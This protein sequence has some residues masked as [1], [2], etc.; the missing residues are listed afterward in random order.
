V[1]VALYHDNRQ[2]RHLKGLR[3]LKE[4]GL[5]PVLGVVSLDPHYR[6]TA[7]GLHVWPWDLFLRQLWQGVLG[8]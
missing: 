7:D 2:Y 8:S 3:A 6:R 4:E 1:I 5:I